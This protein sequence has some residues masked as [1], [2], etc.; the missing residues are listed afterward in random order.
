MFRAWNEMMGY[1]FLI[2]RSVENLR[3]PEGVEVVV[4]S[5]VPLHKG[6]PRSVLSPTPSLTGD[7]HVPISQKGI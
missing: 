4:G 2:P 5:G 3:I 1:D 7:I 6:P